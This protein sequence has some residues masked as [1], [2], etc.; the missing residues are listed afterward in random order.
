MNTDT[1]VTN[2]SKLK[3]QLLEYLLLFLKDLFDTSNFRNTI[4]ASQGFHFYPESL[5]CA[6]AHSNQPTFPPAPS[7]NGSCWLDYSSGARTDLICSISR[8]ITHKSQ[9]SQHKDK[10]VTLS[11]VTPTAVPARGLSARHFSFSRRV[12]TACALQQQVLEWG[13]I[14]CTV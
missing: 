1:H 12:S 11:E 6:E 9:T 5:F 2:P 14:M 7:G 13:R 3:F 4:H 8:E 10:W